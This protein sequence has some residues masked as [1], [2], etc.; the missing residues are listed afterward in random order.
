MYDNGGKERKQEKRGTEISIKHSF[1]WVKCFPVAYHLHTLKYSTENPLSATENQPSGCLPRDQCNGRPVV[2]LLTYR[3]LFYRQLQVQYTRRQ[4]YRPSWLTGVSF[5]VRISVRTSAILAQ[6]LRAFPQ[7]LQR[8]SGMVPV[9]IIELQHDSI[10]GGFLLK[11]VSSR[12]TDLITKQEVLGRTNRLF[13]LI[14]HGPHGKRRVQQFFYC[15]V[16]IRYRGKFSTESLPS[17]D[18]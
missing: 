12:W 8:N 7:S 5:L 1:L 15:C 17:N 9:N 11:Q 16:C 2:R 4:T 3:H 18:R 14:R 13:S 10:T 6:V